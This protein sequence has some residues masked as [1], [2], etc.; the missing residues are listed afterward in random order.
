MTKLPV[1]TSAGGNQEAKD[2]YVRESFFSFVTDLFL[3]KIMP[4]VLVNIFK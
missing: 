4:C 2:I 3:L 1:V